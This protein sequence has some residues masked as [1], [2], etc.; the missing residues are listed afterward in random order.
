[1]SFKWYSFNIIGLLTAFIFTIF[2]FISVALYPTPYNPLYDWVS[3]LGNINL[4]PFGSLF[5]N[6]GC[7]ITGL[8]LI[9]FIISLYQWN[10]SKIWSK[11]F[12][13]I[14]IIL[15]VFASI[16]LI[17]VGVFPE[18]NIN[19]HVVAASGVFGS[20]FIIIT[21]LSIALFNHPKFIHMIAYWG[22]I[23]VLI[24]LSLI[25]IL[26]L[27]ENALTSFHPTMPIPGIEWA[28]VFSSLI[29]VGLLSY[30][31]RRKRIKLIISI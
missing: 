5:F 11:I 31:M 22:I 28:S 17:G 14:G 25:I 27:H 15:G 20:L 13:M 7:I 29:W 21:F 12:L 10:P 6:L 16:S 4:N 23:A 24:D 8:I 19:L 26:S 18:T 2:T 1:M 9:P 3:N 30:N